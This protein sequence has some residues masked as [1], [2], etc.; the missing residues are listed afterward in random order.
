MVKYLL[1]ILFFLLFFVPVLLS[2]KKTA[3]PDG[4]FEEQITKPGVQVLD[5]RTA[6]EYASSHIKNSLQADWLDNKQFK[7]RVQYLDK[8]RPVYVYCGSG[9]RSKDAAKWLRQEGFQQVLELQN[10]FISWKKNNRPVEIDSVVNQMSLTDYQALLKT[11]SVSLVDFGAKWC[12]PCKKMEPVLE[13]L[14]KDLPGKFNLIKV[15]AG[16][17]TNIMQQLKVEILPTFI[18]YKNGKETWRK[19][20]LVSLE[21]FKSQLQ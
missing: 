19:D 20:G 8:A 16:V 2:Q 17:H 3:I 7:E 15:D 18:L 11:S 10:G 14:Q 5:V 9:V 4:E 1:T 21:E 13:Q 6:G 12:P